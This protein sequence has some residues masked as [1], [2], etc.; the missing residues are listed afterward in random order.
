MN[1]G[2]YIKQLAGESF[3]YGFSGIVGGLIGIFLVPVYTRVFSPEDFGIVSLIIV[4]A[5]LVMMVATLALDNSAA[6]WFY[7]SEDPVDR[8]T[9]ISSWFWC[10][11]I[12]SSCLAAVIIATAPFISLLL[13]DTVENAN[14]VRLMAL[15]VPLGAGGM[16]LGNWFRF[17]RLP[18]RAVSFTISRA[19]IDVGLIILFVVFLGFGMVGLFSAQLA[20][21]F[22]VMVA[23]IIF[24]KDW[25][26]PALFSWR[27]LRPMLRYALPLIPAA[28]GLWVMMSMDRIMLKQFAPMS[29][30]GLYAIGAM[31][32]SGVALITSAFSQAWG[33]FAYSI[34]KE[35]ESGRVY[36]RVLDYYSYLGCAACAGVAL[37]APLI[38]RILSTEAYYAAASTVAILSFGTLLNGSRFIAALGC[39]IAKKSGPNAFSV[40]IGAAVNIVLNLLLI[41]LWGRNGA[42]VATVLAWGI[43]AFYLFGA[44][45]RYHYIPYRWSMA[46][47][48]LVLACVLVALDSWMVVGDGFLAYG[49]RVGLM[50]TF[51]PLGMVMGLVNWRVIA[52]R[53]R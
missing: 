15:A 18:V 33:P 50:L 43:S 48:P 28:V 36:A 47:A 16:V 45:Q 26:S 2:K 22:V 24:L 40:G 53:G 25:I 19:L 10:Q 38:L 3:V 12:V 5:G 4:L 23:A 35:P 32:A 34:L 7:D 14:L 39:G 8:K 44:S 27:R 31:V 6:R 51:V 1:I 11:L 49:A 29:E 30:V 9:T 13:T 37:F 41:P 46:I 20:T 42:A 52:G 17:Q 21:A